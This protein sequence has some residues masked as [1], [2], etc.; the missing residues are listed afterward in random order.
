M[1][2]T[3]WCVVECRNEQD[4][5]LCAKSAAPTG[6]AN[7]RLMAGLSL[8]RLQWKSGLETH[9]NGLLQSRYG[10]W[11]DSLYDM[12]WHDRVPMFF[13]IGASGLSGR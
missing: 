11:I 6:G 8:E 2:E 1:V 7:R 9:A 13:A 4:P 10:N 12:F 5:A 3:P